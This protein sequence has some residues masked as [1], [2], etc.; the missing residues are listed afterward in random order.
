MSTEF[1]SKVTKSYDFFLQKEQEGMPFNLSEL[2]AYTGWKESTVSTYPSKKWEN[3]LVK[4]ADGKFTVNGVSKFTAEEYIRMMSQKN[5]VSS[6]PR[7]PG[8]D[9]EVEALVLKARE[10]A[11]LA[12]DIYNR[13]CTQFRTQG[14]IVMMIIAWTALLHA[15]F[16]RNGT[17]YY[18]LDS[19]TGQP[20]MVDGDEKAWELSECVR[21]FYKGQMNAIARNLEFMV[22]LRN[23]IEH[24]F[25]PAIDP[26]VAGECQSILLNFDELLCEEFGEYYALRE[27]LTVPLQTA[28]LRTTT[29]I[30]AVKKFQGENYEKV[31]SF[32]NVYRE[33]LGDDQY[34]DPKFSFRVYLIPKLANHKSSSDI[35]FE[36]VKYDAS[37]P[38]QMQ[39]I[40]R[41]VALVKEKHVPVANEGMYK[42]KDVI[43]EVQKSTTKKF[44]QHTHRQAL[45]H[46]KARLTTETSKPAGKDYDSKYCRPDALHH[47][48]GYTPEWVKFL[49]G[50]MQIAGEYEK[51]C[52]LKIPNKG[53]RKKATKR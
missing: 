7:K 27:H 32:I 50:K 39:E 4:Q 19:K 13:P 3:I 44:T 5:T 14:F 53:G 28:A 10:S 18:H 47:D 9:E 38:E 26:Y 46:Y 40:Q 49:C 2:A 31:M 34:N 37:K 48:W 41:L 11:L 25:L 29:Q 45:I 43:A 35:A 42:A 30:D 21:F 16:Q 20:T 36:F 51:V 23:K 33:S 1:D 12:L 17:K 8:L 15:I 24:R 52:S 6:D 22:K